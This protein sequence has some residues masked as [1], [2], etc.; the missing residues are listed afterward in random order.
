MRK[1]YL[2]APGPTQV[3]PE[4]LLEMAQASIHHR[5]PEFKELFA[6]CRE[7]LKYLFQ[8]RREVLILTTSGT[9]AM[10]ASVTN[11]LCRGDKAK[12]I[13]SAKV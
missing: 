3:A 6:E 10:E 8:T 12:V 1:R 2:M 4:T 7:G 13:E 11:F 9:G 5:E